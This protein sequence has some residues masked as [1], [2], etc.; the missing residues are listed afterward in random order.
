MHERRASERKTRGALIILT[1]S[2]R[3]TCQ[4][5]VYARDALKKCRLSVVERD[6][7]SFPT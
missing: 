7:N 5:I 1:K 6:S 2:E 4:K 3:A